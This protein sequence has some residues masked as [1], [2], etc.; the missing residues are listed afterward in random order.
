[1][2]QHDPWIPIEPDWE[3]ILEKIPQSDPSTR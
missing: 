3:T 2:S 1:M